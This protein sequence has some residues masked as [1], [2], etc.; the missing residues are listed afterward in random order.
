MHI[1]IGGCGRLGSQLT[2]EL[3]Q[4]GHT[5]SIV[6]KRREA[7]E[8][9]PPGFEGQTLL[10]LTFDRETLEAAGIKDADAYIA[11]SS[12]DNSN[13]VSA[14]IAH[15]HYGVKRVIARIYDP[16]RAEIY[17]R[18]GIRTFSTVSW[19][20]AQILDTLFAGGEQTEL[21][22]SDGIFV[23]IAVPIGGHL[24]GHPVSGFNEEDRS[25]VV[26]IDRR[27]KTLLPDARTAFQEGDVAHIAVHR[28]ALKAIREQLEGA[29]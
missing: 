23:L 7:F 24:A 28:D 2:I 12:G 26:A 17:Q 15:E 20:E 19:A 9:L 11:A 21:R 8:K 5:V 13:I 6:D 18:L 29:H 3:N 1:V 10:G 14:R 22:F 16:R 27:G 4:L 25:N